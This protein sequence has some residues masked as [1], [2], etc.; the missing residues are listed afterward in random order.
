M[1]MSSLNRSNLDSTVYESKACLTSDMKM[2]AAI[3]EA[4]KPNLI[5]PT[6]VVNLN[7]FE[8]PKP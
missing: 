4:P 6:P 2:N 1:F 5:R 3:D 7:I 8:Q